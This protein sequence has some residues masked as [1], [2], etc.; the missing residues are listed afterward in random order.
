MNAFRWNNFFLQL[1]PD[2]T[3]LYLGLK[4][5]LDSFVSREN[6]QILKDI[7]RIYT[8]ENLSRDYIAL[9]LV[10][11]NIPSLLFEISPYRLIASEFLCKKPAP[12]ILLSDLACILLIENILNENKSNI[13]NKKVL[14]QLATDIFQF[15]KESLLSFSMKEDKVPSNIKEEYDL[16]IRKFIKRKGKKKIELEYLYEATAGGKSNFLSK[17]DT[18]EKFGEEI[19]LYG[20]SEIDPIH[21]KVL[22]ILSEYTKISFFIPTPR[23][24][25][26]H[27]DDSKIG[28]LKLKELLPEWS[29][30]SKF[31]G[32]KKK[33]EVETLLDLKIPS[34]PENSKFYF[35]ESQETYREIEFVG[36]EILS[37]LE[38]N[39]DNE[40]RLTSIKLVLPAED[41]NYSLL[42]SNTF[43]RMGIPYSFTKDI[44]KKKSPYFS[45]VA[46]LLKLS[47]SDF[48]KETIFSLFYNPCFYPALED[49]RIKIKPEIWNQIISRMNVSGFLDKQHKKNLGLRESNLMT[50]ESLWNRL[51]S[52]L[53]GD[54]SEDSIAFESEL[55]EEVFQFLEISS[56]LLQDL[57]GMKEDFSSL[58]DFSKF[59]K[60]LL[61]TYLHPSMR[62]SQSDEIQRLN[63]R[64]QTK[65]YNL[66]A[67]IESIDAELKFLFKDNIRFALEDFVDI[68]LGLLESWRDG[69]A[70]VLKHGVVV[71]ELVDVIDPTFDYIYL[72]GLDERRFSIHSS[73]NDSIV[74]EDTIYSSRM[75]SALK[76]KNYFYH[77]FNQNA[78]RYTFSYVSLDTI[79]DREYYPAREIEWIKDLV[80]QEFQKIPLFSY[81]EYKVET[82]SPKV[83]EKEA[84]DLIG[85]KK[86]ESSLSLL[87]NSY[88]VWADN[89]DLALTKEV[90]LLTSEKKMNK[91]IKS[92]FLRPSFD[93]D[94]SKITANM[95]LSV[96][97]FINYLECPKKFF[98][99]YSIRAKEEEEEL[100][101]IDSVDSLRRHVFIK[102]V[103]SYLKENSKPDINVLVRKIFNSKRQ[104][105]GEIPFGVLGKVA[106]LEFADY[107]EKEIIPFYFDDLRSYE[108]YENIIFNEEKNK[109]KN[110]IVF[111]SPIVWEQKF[112]VNVDYIIIQGEV[113][114]L[115]FL[116]TSKE[117]KNKKNILAG[118]A[119][120]LLDKS[121]LIKEEL[122]KHFQLDKMKLAPAI[123]HFP[124]NKKPSFIYGA[125]AEIEEDTFKVFWES[126]KEGKF[127]ASPMDSSLC[128][129]CPV[130]TVCYGYQNE[131][132]PFLELERKEIIEKSQKQFP[133]K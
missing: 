53:I 79:K 17:E 31:M 18:V 91:K 76:L 44:R 87:K 12:E 105:F 74:M 108:L 95:D 97:K 120:H 119:T 8:R 107:I 129:Y 116:T 42:V 52:T 111:S 78:K 20:V 35:F 13:S 46:S 14:R 48:D 131:F 115:T 19:I 101:E 24:S 37:L 72:L 110:V 100:G 124:K 55:L 98:F 54:S 106:E 28:S 84:F 121:T 68:F 57:I 64:G 49:I 5:E 80:K 63:E 117:I 92:Y 22:E 103:I 10:E 16:I 47:T 39:K 40:F 7:F 118:F 60:I 62:Y 67:E 99:D 43:D 33:S 34:I 2:N 113:V 29:V 112:K 6:V 9:K 36:R 58:S 69:D 109:T 77:I 96:N 133:K 32:D 61:D 23:L 130:N 123:L 114:Y 3:A 27:K 56:S 127:P 86:K 25:L 81:L 41:L 51:N 65:V 126:L 38:E 102:E 1:F 71:G 45:A 11:D 93:K 83:F 15:W 90:D 50:W 125:N 26:I 89:S 66:L 88:P 94:H 104:E 73:K 30:L 128:E 4:K 85:L 21:F 132:F 75:D 122:K 70:K 82:P 59:F